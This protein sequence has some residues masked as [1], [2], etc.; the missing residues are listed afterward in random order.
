MK[1]IKKLLNEKVQSISTNT[2]D[3]LVRIQVNGER[4]IE[5]KN[6]SAIFGKPYI[7]SL[8]SKHETTTNKKAKA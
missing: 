4:F 1:K 7:H 5:C 2:M 6:P 3:S 8:Q